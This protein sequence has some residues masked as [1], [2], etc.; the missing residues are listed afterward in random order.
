MGDFTDGSNEKGKDWSPKVSVGAQGADVG[1]GRKPWG[2]YLRS[3]RGLRR[4]ERRCGRAKLEKPGSIGLTFA[5]FLQPLPTLKRPP[6][7]WR[8]QTSLGN[9]E[10]LSGANPRRT[11]VQWVKTEY[12][13]LKPKVQDRGYAG[14]QG[15]GR[16]HMRVIIAGARSCDVD[17]KFRYAIAA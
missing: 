1:E 10:V 11:R 6:Y 15:T 4:W 3:A 14:G 2:M 7:S 16:I 5:R 9:F 12:K 17:C 8:R 13:D